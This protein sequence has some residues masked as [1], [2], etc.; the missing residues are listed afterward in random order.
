MDLVH[1]VETEEAYSP[2]NIA[3]PRDQGIIKGFGLAMD[4]A[5][6]CIENLMADNE[7]EGT[8]SGR[9]R[10][11]WLGELLDHLMTWMEG[12]RAERVV[13]IVENLPDG[14]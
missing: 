9:L 11:E 13:S 4:D 8:L 3:D 6:C 7:L 1:V 10:N 12:S 5:K 2:D 14:E